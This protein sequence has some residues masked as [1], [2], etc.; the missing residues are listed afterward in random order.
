MRDIESTS[1]PTSTTSNSQPVRIVGAFAGG[2]ASAGAAGGLAVG[3][4]FASSGAEGGT[5]P[6]IDKPSIGVEV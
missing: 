4:G 3:Y 5:G 2:F 1:T 6:G